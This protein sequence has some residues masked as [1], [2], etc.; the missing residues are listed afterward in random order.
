MTN[1]S[2]HNIYKVSEKISHEITKELH[3]KIQSEDMTKLVDEI[4]S[5][6]HD[7]MKSCLPKKIY[8]SVEEEVMFGYEPSNKIESLIETLLFGSRWIMALVFL[9]GAFVMFAL[10]LEVAGDIIRLI[11]MSW[12]FMENLSI[13]DHE[14]IAKHKEEFIIETLTILDHLL[15][16]SL[17]VMVL[18]SGYENTVSRIKVGEGGPSW[19]GKIGIS[20]LKT[21]IASSIVAISSIHLL[22]IFLSLEQHNI[23][24]EKFNFNVMWAVIIHLVFIV[25]ALILAYVAR[26]HPEDAH[27]NL[28]GECKIISTDSKG[29]LTK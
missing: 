23:I 19:L 3:K 21:K 1:T 15:I 11:P 29:D 14:Q 10:L 22:Q 25:S 12:H 28:E 24:E 20:D 6:V 2:E 13:Y 26:M 27:A 8:K 7:N 5:S 4:V 16:G 18:V 9:I 17:I